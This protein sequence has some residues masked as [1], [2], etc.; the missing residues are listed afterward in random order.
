MADSSSGAVPAKSAK[1]RRT[2]GASAKS[3]TT[4]PAMIC[5]PTGWSLYSSEVA[6]PKF[7]P[8]PRR[9][10]SRSGLLVGARRHPLAVGGDDL[11]GE[12]VVARGPVLAGDPA[13]PAAEGQAGHA[14]ERDVAGWRGEAEGLRRAVDV[15]QQSAGAHACRPSDGVDLDRPL[16]REV[17]D[18]AGVA[19]RVAGDVVA[20]APHGQRQPVL[21]REA[22]RRDDVVLVS[23]PG[24]E[25]RPAIDHAVPDAPRGFVLPV[26]GTD[27]HPGEGAVQSPDRGLIEHGA[28]RSRSPDRR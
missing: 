22:H 10:Q 18:H 12:Q 21:A 28:S 8:P 9:P 7:P 26:A 20:P 2:S 19:H 16:G 24:D 14:G 3:W 13:E 5:G 6:M 25:R 1:K 17:D 27:Q 4:P 11:R 15:A 23:A